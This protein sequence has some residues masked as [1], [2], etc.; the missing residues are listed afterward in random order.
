[1]F[2]CWD[3]TGEG[4]IRETRATDA[5]D[6]IN[7]WIEEAGPRRLH[8]WQLQPPSLA[9]TVRN[10][11]GT[12]TVTDGPFAETKEQIGGYDMLECA[13]LD[14]AIG[15]AARHGAPVLDLRPIPAG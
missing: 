1:M 9:R 11:D 5:D 2:V 7:G 14:E 6:P 12:V 3:Q 13:D 8:G 4:E 15:I 10:V